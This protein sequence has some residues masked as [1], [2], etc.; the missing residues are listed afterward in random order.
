MGALPE[1][2]P[3][4]DWLSGLSLP[5]G[6]GPKKLSTNLQLEESRFNSVVAR[7]HPE[8]PRGP[9]GPGPPPHPGPWAGSPQPRLLPS[10]KGQVFTVLNILHAWLE[11]GPPDGQAASPRW[12]QGP[13]STHPSCII[14]RWEEPRAP[15]ISKE[16][17]QRCGLLELA[18]PDAAPWL[19]LPSAGLLRCRAEEALRPGGSTGHAGSWNQEPGPPAPPPR[20]PLSL[21][22]E[23]GH[24]ACRSSNGQRGCRCTLASPSPLRPMPRLLL[25]SRWSV[26]PP[27]TL[28]GGERR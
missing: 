4:P 27:L 5:A 20:A 21:R 23:L 18:I 26:P 15:K 1:A 6:R 19:E 2:V 16:K 7:L 25:E 14:Y 9:P 24:R 22:W 28:A 10:G 8:L 11:A 12:G 13:R 3:A 17:R